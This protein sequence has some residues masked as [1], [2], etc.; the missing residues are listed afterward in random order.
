MERQRRAARRILLPALTLLLAGTLLALWLPQRPDGDLT[1]IAQFDARVGDGLL[2]RLRM[3]FLLN[4]AGALVGWAALVE[5]LAVVAR[6]RPRTWA[7]AAR[8][9]LWGGL[10]LALVG[11][12]W[13]RS[14]GWEGELFLAP[15]DR[16]PVGPE[17]RPLLRFERFTLPPAPD[18]PGRALQM[19]LTVDD[20]SWQ[21]SEALPYR[22][23]GWTF[24]PRW[25][26][27]LVSAPALRAPIYFGA[28]GIQTVTRRDGREATVEVDLDRLA[29][30]VEPPLPEGPPRV[31]YYAI[32]RA[33]FAPG[34]GL[35]RLG[36]GVALGGAL[37]LTVARTYNPDQKRTVNGGGG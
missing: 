34:T 26:G 33:R 29:Y 22:G 6:G 15:G 11:W 2:H 1:A 27:A 14:R 12:G 16:V 7:E 23:Q 10:L 13:N 24:A 20:R 32:L 8:W 4:L 35:L 36:L 37:L 30:R 21:V 18:G 31:E 9:A 3:S 5:G 25:Y 17:Q 28:S 19:V